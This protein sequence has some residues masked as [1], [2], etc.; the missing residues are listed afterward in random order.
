M[1]RLFV[2]AATVGLMLCPARAQTPQQSDQQ[3]T[4]QQ[5]VQEVNELKARIAALE[6]KQAQPAPVPAP[7]GQTQAAGP[8]AAPPVPE[9]APYRMVRG[10]QFQGFG[11]VTYRASDVK[12][13][14][15]P[16]IGLKPGS[17]GNFTVGDVDL[18][19]TSHL[20]PKLMV[21]S[22]VVF[23]EGDDQEFET[24]V[25]RMLLKYDMNDRLKMSF[26]RFHTATSYYNSVFHHGNWLQT[27]VD[28]PLV[29]EFSDHGG[30]LPSQAVGMSMTGSLPSGPLGLNYIFEY[31]TGDTVR[32]LINQPDP[33]E[34]DEENG[35]HLNGGFFIKPDFL[36]GLDIGGSF[37]HDRINPEG[38]PLHI[39]QGIGSVHAVYVTPKFE[40][41][42]EG[43]LIRHKVQE[44]GVTFNTPAFYAL[45]SHQIATHWRPYFRFQYAN[46]SPVEPIFSDVSL[47]YG[48]T[49]GIRFDFNDYVALKGQYDRTFRRGL[50]SFNEAL[51][52]MAFRF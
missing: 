7:A 13:P 11:A 5:L 18:F 26:G 41:L 52:Q 51:A 25:E 44:T 9:S 14:E 50:P 2:M 24:D 20:T 48:P 8:Q 37:Y 32:P 30:M 35:N 10:I 4:I 12:P 23:S 42:T 29:V 15:A 45:I 21:L 31:G 43:F 40:L 17:T 39:D 38:S 1:H 28:R 16:L 33:P 6:A 47:R 46:A 49:A 27:A 34:I 36:P 3:E 19:L 22:E